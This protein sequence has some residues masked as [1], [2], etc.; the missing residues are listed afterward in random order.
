MLSRD[1]VLSVIKY[2]NL[3]SLPDTHQYFP[4]MNAIQNLASKQQFNSNKQCLVTDFFHVKYCHR[5]GDC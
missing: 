4:Y 5:K 2:H 3:E 1:D